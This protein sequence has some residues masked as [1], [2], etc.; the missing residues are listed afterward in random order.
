MDDVIVEKSRKNQPQEV[1]GNLHHGDL[2]WQ[3]DAV[4]VVDPAMTAIGRQQRLRRVG[5]GKMHGRTLSVTPGRSPI[6]RMEA[7]KGSNWESSKTGMKTALSS[8]PVFQIPNSSGLLLSRRLGEGLHVLDGGRVWRTPSPSPPTATLRRHRP[9]RPDGRRGS[10]EAAT[11]SSVCSVV[12]RHGPVARRSS[13]ARSLAT[14]TTIGGFSLAAPVRGAS[15]VSG[16]V[17]FTDGWF[18]KVVVTS[19]NTSHHDQHVDQ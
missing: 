17:S 12:G 1:A 9:G 8:F 18:L 13:A 4:E 11:L 10:A 7:E 19:R 6:P 5:D 15:L 14:V 2:G 16:S 3:V